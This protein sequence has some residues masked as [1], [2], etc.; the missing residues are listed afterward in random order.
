MEQL[1][2]P[3]DGLAIWDFE[4]G[5]ELPGRNLA[6][7]RLGVGTRCETWLVWNPELWSPAVLKLA[8]PH[9][10]RHPRAVRT[11]RRETAA[12]TSNP[13]PALPRLLADGTTAPVP[14]IVMEYVD[15]PAL[16]E[17]LEETGALT[18]A[19]AA[20]LGS[21]LLPA[22]AS[23]HQ[24]G[25]AHLDLKPENVVLRDARPILIDFGTARRIGATQ[26]KGHP[27]GTAGYAAPEQEACEPVSAAMD[28]FGLG[29][30]LAEAVTGVPLAEGVEI[31]ASPLLPVIEQLLAEQPEK[32]GTTADVLVALA[33]AAGELRPWP[34]WLDRH[35]G[36]AVSAGAGSE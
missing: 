21:Q 13:H 32:R 12:L 29:M 27:V 8:R 31:P 4:E 16:D 26:R 22:V 19:E 24:R 36:T 18:V 11:L 7:E 28:L 17:E 2:D 30:I 1:L 33:D 14:H 23:L 10:I 9:Q 34:D 6:I 20:V 25:L 5:S 35:A 3:D 15:G